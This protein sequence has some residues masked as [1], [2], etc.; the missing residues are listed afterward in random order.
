MWVTGLKGCL[1]IHAVRYQHRVDSQKNKGS[2][3]RLHGCHFHHYHDACGY[4]SLPNDT[5]I[6]R[7]YP[8]I[9][10]LCPEHLESKNWILRDKLISVRV[11]DA[12]QVFAETKQRPV[13]CKVAE[14]KQNHLGWLPKYLHRLWLV[15]TSLPSTEC[16]GYRE[17]TTGGL[18]DICSP[19]FKNLMKKRSNFRAICP[20]LWCSYHENWP[21]G[22]NFSASICTA[23]LRDFAFWAPSFYILSTNL[24]LYLVF[25]KNFDSFLPRE[26]TYAEA[27][28]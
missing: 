12:K 3:H 19:K 17:T 6:T 22:L 24:Q 16:Q 23:T 26:R 7:I 4:D 15:S 1:K 20:D 2:H 9:P 11:K 28:W 25:L 21:F 13:F 5:R 10:L 27:V 18:E 8:Y 14:N